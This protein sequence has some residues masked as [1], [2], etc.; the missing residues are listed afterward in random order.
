M[1][2][3]TNN[4]IGVNQ[5]PKSSFVMPNQIQKGLDN[6]ADAEPVIAKTIKMSVN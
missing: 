2:K 5:N 6:Q 1:G 4:R 3:M